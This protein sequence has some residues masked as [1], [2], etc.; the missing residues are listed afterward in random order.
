MGQTLCLLDLA[1]QYSR[2]AESKV[3]TYG[4][5]SQPLSGQEYKP[6][7]G[8]TGVMSMLEKL[9]KDTSDLTHMEQDQLHQ[10]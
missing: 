9:I 1:L 4:R 8:S 5:L 6:S 2:N 3:Q 7:E 10:L